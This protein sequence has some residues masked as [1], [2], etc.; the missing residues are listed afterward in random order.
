MY[1]FSS[2]AEFS[3]I[4]MDE[5]AA[6]RALRD[7]MSVGLDIRG[8]LL[9][10]ATP[11]LVIEEAYGAMAPIEAS[12]LVGTSFLDLL[13]QDS[14]VKLKEALTSASRAGR[15]ESEGKLAIKAGTEEIPVTFRHSTKI[16]SRGERVV[17]GLRDDRLIE[18]VAQSAEK[19]YRVESVGAAAASFVSAFEKMFMA[20]QGYIGLMMFDNLPENMRPQIE[21]IADYARRGAALGEALQRIACGKRAA[22]KLMELSSFRDDY[23]R[24][25]TQ[26]FSSHR[27][28][29]DESDKTVFIEVDPELLSLAI[30]ALLSNAVE[31]THSEGEISVETGSEEISAAVA[32]QTGKLRAG[33]YAFIRIRDNGAGISPMDLPRAFEPLFTTK[34]RHKGL[35]LVAAQVAV[36]AN[37]GRMNLKSS[38]GKGTTAE[39]FIPIEKRTAQPENDLRGNGQSV[40]LI[41]PAEDWLDALSKILTRHNFQPSG[42]LRRQDAL[43]LLRLQ[44]FDIVVF[45]P[46][47]G[48]ADS[49]V[50]IEEVRRIRPTVPIIVMLSAGEMRAFTRLV[51]SEDVQVVVRSGDVRQIVRNV[52]LL[53][54]L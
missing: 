12:K 21:R 50:F 11:S 37:G 27:I 30:F 25:L 8:D 13:D 23:I 47:R 15:Y 24:P 31:A 40:L 49:A 3:T 39:I 43:K 28:T 2:L 41:N 4:A 35:G 7:I 20:I 42:V 16:L 1:L 54:K 48:G 5:A 19:A 18:E 17:I 26:S 44:P 32:T 34:Q 51:K 36:Q 22:P 9:L 14:L 45:D 29:V 6:E 33:Y 10:V 52:K 53:L 38:T 46:E